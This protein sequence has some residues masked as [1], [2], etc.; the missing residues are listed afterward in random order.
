[1]GYTGSNAAVIT[2]GTIGVADR[3]YSHFDYPRWHPLLEPT[4]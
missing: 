1:M 3:S 2:G 4:W